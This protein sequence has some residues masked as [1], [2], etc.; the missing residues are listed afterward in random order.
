MQTPLSVLDI[1]EATA[2][3]AAILAGIGAGVYRDAQDALRQITSSPMIVEP[4]P[5]AARW[6]DRYFNEVFVDLYEALRPLNHRIHDLL[7]A[8]SPTN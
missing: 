7:S 6:Y 2:L 8:D 3:G 1:D 5:E 4:E